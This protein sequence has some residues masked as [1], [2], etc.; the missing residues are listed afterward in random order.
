MAN[1][2]CHYHSALFKGL[3]LQC[4]GMPLLKTLEKYSSW[5]LGYLLHHSLDLAFQ[6]FLA[7]TLL[8]LHSTDQ[9]VKNAL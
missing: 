1:N 9:T 3:P 6:L 8:L 7:H 5:L 2:D 4:L